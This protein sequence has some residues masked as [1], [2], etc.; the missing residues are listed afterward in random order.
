MYAENLTL[1]FLLTCKSPSI[2]LDYLWSCWSISIA[3]N[4]WGR[5]LNPASSHF[6]SISCQAISSNSDLWMLF[7]LPVYTDFQ[8]LWTSPGCFQRITR[9]EANNLNP[10]CLAFTCSISS[11]KTPLISSCNSCWLTD[12]WKAL[13]HQL[14]ALIF[15]GM[16]DIEKLRPITN[17]YCY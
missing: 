12:N 15:E 14:C 11:R 2:S 1:S 10:S 8:L 3:C 13:D 17:A 9:S 7:Q 16:L 6:T 4:L 5:F